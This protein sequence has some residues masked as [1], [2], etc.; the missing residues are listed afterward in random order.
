LEKIGQ[1]SRLCEELMAKL[2]ELQEQN[3]ELES[4]LKAQEL[5]MEKAIKNIKKYLE[6]SD[7]S[8]G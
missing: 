8:R 1:L 3:K 7:E 2:H 5:E 4:K 6:L